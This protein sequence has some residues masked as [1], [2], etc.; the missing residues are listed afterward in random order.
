MSFKILNSKKKYKNIKEQYGSTI[1]N[2]INKYTPSFLIK[3]TQLNF[4]NKMLD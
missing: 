2:K 1:C 3:T 4:D